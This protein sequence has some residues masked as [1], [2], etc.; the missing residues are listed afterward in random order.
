MR[1]V[2]LKM[3]PIIIPT[4]FVRKSE[5]LEARL[6]QYEGIVDRVQLDVADEAFT[7]E[8][9]LSTEKM[10]SWPTTLDRDVHLMT[11]EPA[12][13]LEV[14]AK[15]GIKTAIGQIENMSS[16]REFV[17]EAKALGLKAGL[18]IDLETDLEEL[19]W[20]V[21]KKADQLLVMMVRAGKEGQTLSQEGLKRVRL[22]RQKGFEKEIC[23]DGGVNEKTIELCVKAGADLLAVGSCLWQAEE[24]E[25]QYRRLKELAEQ[26][27]TG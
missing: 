19:D 20:S 10:V 13:W 23:V 25:K 14:C 17:E 6:E 11:L 12:D 27:Q 9:T 1:R 5:T 7:S 24:V 4:I 26:A 18:A 16:Q 15:E 3:K 2:N 8:P 22:L 21:A